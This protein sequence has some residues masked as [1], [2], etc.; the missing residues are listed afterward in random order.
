MGQKKGRIGFTCAYTPLAIIDAAGFTPFRLLPVGNWPDQAGRVLHD[1]MCPHVKRVLDCAMSDDLPPDLAGMVFVNSCDAMRRM[2][3]AWRK[4]RPDDKV[5]LI[6]LPTTAEPG[7]VTYFSGQLRMLSDRL[8]EWGGNPVTAD[9]IETGIE[10]FNTVSTLLREIEL[11]AR[12]KRL[13]GG[14]SR[15]QTLYNRASTEDADTMI[16]DLRQI[17]GE[18]PPQNQ[19]SAVPVFLFGNMFPDPTAYALFESSGAHV[20]GDDFCTGS[21]LFAPMENHISGDVFD[22][23]AQQLFA[24]P[25][26]ART[27]FPSQPANVANDILQRTRA[28]GAAG[29]IGHIMKFCDPYL[30]RMPLVRNAFKEAGLPLLILEGDCTLGSIGQQRTRIEAFI[31]MLR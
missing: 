16:G 13:S 10:T 21:R 27:V 24:H 19:S 3:D 14:R 5:A 20:A 31:E 4:L 6:D 2:A 28:S 1:N 18:A 15:M 26:C 17:I 7:S 9:A 22:R 30:T 12:G 11:L 29:A 8:S 23:L 25:P